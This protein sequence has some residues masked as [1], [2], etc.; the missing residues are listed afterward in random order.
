MLV[1]DDAHLGHLRAFEVF[2]NCGYTQSFGEGQPASIHSRSSATRQRISLPPRRTG[3]GIALMSR[4]RQRV[5]DDTFKRWAAVLVSISRPAFSGSFP[6]NNAERSSIALTRSCCGTLTPVV[7]AQF[8]HCCSWLICR[9]TTRSATS[10]NWT[11]I[12]SMSI[13]RLFGS[14]LTVLGP[15]IPAWDTLQ[16]PPSN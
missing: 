9:A 10:P 6:S 1:L 16:Q 3:S 7:A 12:A 5:R 11:V 4:R 15:S 8:S 14:M 13:S 2:G